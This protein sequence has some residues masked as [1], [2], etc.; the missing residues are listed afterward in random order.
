MKGLFTGVDSCPESLQYGREEDAH[1]RDLDLEG[2]IKNKA[3]QSK[4]MAK[5]YFNIILIVPK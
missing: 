4:W 3:A 1:N 5:Y 2:L